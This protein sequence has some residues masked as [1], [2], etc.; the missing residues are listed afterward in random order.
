MTTHDRHENFLLQFLSPGVHNVQK[1]GFS[2]IGRKIILETVAIYVLQDS[3][4]IKIVLEYTSYSIKNI[5][6][7][8]R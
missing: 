7:L 4:H 6:N 8:F 2:L 3:R 5:K 1:N